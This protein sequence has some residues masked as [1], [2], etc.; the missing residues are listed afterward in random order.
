MIK[1]QIFVCHTSIKF[2]HLDKPPSLFADIVDVDVGL[3]SLLHDS[4]SC[5]L[6]MLWKARLRKNFIEFA[7]LLCAF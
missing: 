2:K 1:M 4:S 7:T 5:V 6:G 3:P